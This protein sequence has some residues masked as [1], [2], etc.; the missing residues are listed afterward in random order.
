[1]QWLW[2]CFVW[3][4]VDIAVGLR[5]T[6][7]STKAKAIQAR[8]ATY[9]CARARPGHLASGKYVQEEACLMMA[10]GTETQTRS[11]AIIVLL[12]ECK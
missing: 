12:V 1:M 5:L 9:D 4:L 8:G 7:V 2:L 3:L 11:Q 10:S 6:K